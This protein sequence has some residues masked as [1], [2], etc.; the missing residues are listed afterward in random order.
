MAAGKGLR[1]K[2]K[3]SEND[4]SS[5]QSVARC[6]VILDDL[7]IICV[8]DNPVLFWMNIFK[9]QYSSGSPNSEHIHFCVLCL[10]FGAPLVSYLLRTQEHLRSDII[11]L[12]DVLLIMGNV[13]KLSRKFLWDTQSKTGSL[14][15]H[16]NISG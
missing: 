7:T 8:N 5:V 12:R 3:Y 6:Y 4:I 1:N 14:Q 13:A 11:Y 2:Q 15:I 10:R 9:S 16:M